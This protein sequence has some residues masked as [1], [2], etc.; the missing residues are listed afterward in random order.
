MLFAP[1]MA[2]FD[3]AKIIEV[4]Y[5]IQLWGREGCV[6]EELVFAEILIS[7]ILW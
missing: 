4:E 7:Y 1:F 3:G 5:D 6:E 2:F